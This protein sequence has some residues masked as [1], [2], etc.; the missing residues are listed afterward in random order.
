MNAP[1]AWTLASIAV[2]IIAARLSMTSA[3]LKLRATSIGRAAF[4]AARLVYYL[5]LPYAALLTGAFPAREVGLHG[6]P[7]LDGLLG[8]PPEAWVRALGSAVA[9]AVSALIVVAILTRQIRRAGGHAASALNAPYVSAAQSIREAVY[10]EAHWSFY[11]ALPALAL[12]DVI[13]AALVA[14]AIIVVEAR[15]AGPQRIRLFDALPAATSATFFAL[16]GGNVWIAFVLQATL[17]IAMTAL[18]YPADK[19]DPQREVIV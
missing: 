1:V 9:L 10:A 19:P 12:N 11:R 17:R 8:W 6:S 15:L 7:S 3:G 4:E 16:T 18:I 14:L 2:F 13:W 5:G